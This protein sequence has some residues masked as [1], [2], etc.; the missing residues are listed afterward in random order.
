MALKSATAALKRAESRGSTTRALW[1]RARTG[2]SGVRL[3][4]QGRAE[5][6]AELAA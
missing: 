4:W 2:S 6:A 5:L 1:L 3:T